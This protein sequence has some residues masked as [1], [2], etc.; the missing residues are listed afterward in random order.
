MHFW[1]LTNTLCANYLNV[2]FCLFGMLVYSK[3]FPKHYLLLQNAIICILLLA[4]LHAS[5][6]NEEKYVYQ[7]LD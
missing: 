5:V 6:F 4:G 3:Y 2:F 1:W 7:D